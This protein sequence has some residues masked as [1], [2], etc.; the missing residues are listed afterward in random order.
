MLREDIARG[1]FSRQSVRR[2]YTGEIEIKFGNFESFANLTGG[3]IGPGSVNFMGC[4][5]WARVKRASSPWA[6]PWRL[7]GPVT[8]GTSTT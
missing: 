6:D 4:V 2:R 7:T 3:Q 1:E 8:V 5:V